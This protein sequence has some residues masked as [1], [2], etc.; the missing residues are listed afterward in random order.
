[1]FANEVL[2]PFLKKYFY[3]IL[4]SSNLL[5]VECPDG[6]LLLT[7]KLQSKGFLYVKLKSSRRTWLH[8]YFTGEHSTRCCINAVDQ[9]DGS[10]AMIWAGFLSDTKC[11]N[12]FVMTI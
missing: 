6:R 9:W 7:R 10:T 5:T 8:L 2:L 4:T 3:S 1:M 12:T 11:L